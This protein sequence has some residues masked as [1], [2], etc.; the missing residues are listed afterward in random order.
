M[1]RLGDVVWVVLCV[2]LGLHFVRV[3]DVLCV[4]WGTYV[5]LGMYCV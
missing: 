2:G 1:C 5:G 4:G 3:G